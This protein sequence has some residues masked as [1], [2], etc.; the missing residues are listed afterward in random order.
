MRNRRNILF[1]AGFLLLAAA[2]FFLT[3]GF[4][5]FNISL[6]DAVGAF[7]DHLLGRYV[8]PA[9]DRY[10]WDVRTPRAIAA[11]VTGAALSVAGVIMQNDFRNP[12][13][14]PYTMGISSGAFLGAVLSLVLGISIFP[15]LTGNAALVANAFVLALI[16]MVII[17]VVTRFKRLTPTAMILLGI[18]VMYLFSSISQVIM[19]TAPSETLADAYSWRVGSFSSIRWESLPI[20]TV[21]TV[22]MILVL[23]LLSGKMNIM[24]SGDTGAQTLGE[25]ASVIRIVTLA[26]VSLLTASVVSFT[27]TIG[28]IGLVGPHVARIFVGSNNRYLIPASMA[29]GAAFMLLA[30]TVAKVSGTNGLPVGVI[31]SMIGG[32]LFIWILI[33][34]RRSAWL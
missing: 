3:L 1:I 30:D 28:F 33:K 29:F 34:Q 4:G 20:M 13:A 31:S 32:P 17:V 26:I 27:G 6:T 14:D 7:F 21:V 9:V 16:P 12:L 5:V 18:A 2:S 10:I 23:W 19:V 11:I 24:Y 22:S 15:F 8:D 25:K